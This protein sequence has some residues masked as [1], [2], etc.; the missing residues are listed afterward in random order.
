M[1]SL[2]Q[3]AN[4]YLSNGTFPLGQYVQNYLDNNP[5]FMLDKKLKFGE[6][7]EVTNSNASMFY[8]NRLIYFL[9]MEDNKEKEL[10]RLSFQYFMGTATPP[11]ASGSTG[12]VSTGN[13]STGNVSTGNVPTG[14]VPTGNNSTATDPNKKQ[15]LFA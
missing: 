1:Y 7:I 8:P 13:V 12:N 15:G 10:K 6:K 14:N 4:Y 2:Q 9:F 11:A 5:T 3:E